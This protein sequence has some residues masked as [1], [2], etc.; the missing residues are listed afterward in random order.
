MK[1]EVRIDET[2]IV[3]IPRH[4]VLT[5]NGPSSVFILDK[6]GMVAA[7]IKNGQRWI[8]PS[9]L[10]L[11]GGKS[12]SLV[13]QRKVVYRVNGDRARRSPDRPAGDSRDAGAG[14]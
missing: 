7:E 8:H 14:G 11:R 4:H 2:L 13:D 6:N 12:N 1:Y 10:A 9:K 5:N 3:D